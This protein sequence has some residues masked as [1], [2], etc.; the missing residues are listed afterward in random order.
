M[1]QHQVD[2]GQQT[3]NPGI[4]QALP[5]ELVVAQAGDHAHLLGQRPPRVFEA[6]I[7]RHRPDRQTTGQVDLQAQHCQLDDFVLPVVQAG[8]LGV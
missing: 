2:A 6:V 7:N 5:L 3:G 4:V 1:G 8:G